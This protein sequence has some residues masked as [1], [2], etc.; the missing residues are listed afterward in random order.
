MG[1]SPSKNIHSS[2]PNIY[3][4]NSKGNYNN[5]SLSNL[6]YLKTFELLIKS[7]LTA[8]NTSTLKEY[9]KTSKASFSFTYVDS[10]SYLYSKYF[11]TL[12]Y[13]SLGISFDFKN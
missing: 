12:A 8:A 9:D 11:L 5:N 1:S 3:S 7:V 6:F 10:F 2:G 13:K 4:S